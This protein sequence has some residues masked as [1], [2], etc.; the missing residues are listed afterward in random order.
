MR[1]DRLIDFL[2]VQN[3][4]DNTGFP[5]YDRLI[6]NSGWHC[7]GTDRLVATDAHT[8]GHPDRGARVGSDHSVREADDGHEASLVHELE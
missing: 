7:A 3:Y 5:S 8:G 6:W 4:L 1:H 2:E